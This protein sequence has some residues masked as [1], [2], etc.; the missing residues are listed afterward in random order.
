METS[1]VL[2]D[3]MKFNIFHLLSSRHYIFHLVI[4]YF[5]GSVVEDIPLRFIS[6]CLRYVFVGVVMCDMFV[7]VVMCIFCCVCF[8]LGDER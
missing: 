2:T 4:L 5:H 8:C 3:P 6:L 7:R 1:S